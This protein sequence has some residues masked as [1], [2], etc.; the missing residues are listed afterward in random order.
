M[1]YDYCTLSQTKMEYD[2]K[3][4]EPI[5]GTRR[6]IPVAYFAPLDEVNVVLTNRLFV[7]DRK[8]GKGS[9]SKEKR[10][11]RHEVT[12]QGEF[13]DAADMPPDFRTAVQRLFGRGDVTAEM[14]WRQLQNIMLSPTM[15]SN[16]SL[17]LGNASYTAQNENELPSNPAQSRYP[18]VAFDEL[19]RDQDTKSTRI[20]YTVRFIA[21]FEKA[22]GA[23]TQ[24]DPPPTAG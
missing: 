6:D 20:R 13:V 5:P 23:V 4:G 1:T 14:Q 17:K 22:K 9:I 15:K 16:Y 21:G 18:Q 19:R 7:G 12:L 10:I 11:Y 24:E 3:T 8:D 2:E